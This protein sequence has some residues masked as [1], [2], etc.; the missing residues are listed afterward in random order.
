MARPRLAFRPGRSWLHRLHPLVKLG[1]LALL[2]LAPFILPTGAMVATALAVALL[3]LWT[4]GLRSW[5]EVPG[6][7]VLAPT[8]LLLFAL[9]ALFRHEGHVVAHLWPWGA[10]ALPV[11]NVGLAVGWLVGGRFLAIVLLSY[12][13]LLCT[14]PNDLAYA[15]MAA[16]LPYRYGFMLVTALR[17][18][19]IFEA[20]GSTVYE[21][22]LARG[23]RYDARSPLRLFT[24]LRRLLLP[25]L[26]SALGKVDALAVSMEGRGFGQ[27]PDRTFLREV[28]MSRPDWAALALLAL[29]AVG[30]AA[31]RLAAR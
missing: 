11:T 28:R 19:P 7:R 14:E 26:V 18:M 23:V 10:G 13:L 22:Q 1:W 25:L 5:R 4:V 30:L 29:V 16:G 24:L 9:Q 2:S 27:Y 15:L 21:A 12:A 6:L 31:W 17:L 8:A 20:E 3:A